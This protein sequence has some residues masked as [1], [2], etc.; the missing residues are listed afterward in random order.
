MF[1]WIQLICIV[2]EKGK[3]V[4]VFH[5]LR[6]CSHLKNKNDYNFFTNLLK[7]ISKLRKRSIGK[8]AFNH[9][10]DNPIYIGKIAIPEYGDE[11][12]QL[13]SAICESTIFEELF[14]N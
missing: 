13:T 2:N 1:P 10:L 6:L 3:V 9:M 8:T 11:G 5:S 14:S 7:S 4:K 12:K